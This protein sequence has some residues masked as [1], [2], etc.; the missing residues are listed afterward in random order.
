MPLALVR[1]VTVQK[2]SPFDAQTTRKLEYYFSPLTP[3]YEKISKK[4]VA[5]LLRQQPDSVEKF[6]E[7][8]TPAFLE[9]FSD[10]MTKMIAA[11][12]P[13]GI[14]QVGRLINQVDLPSLINKAGEV[15]SPE[16]RNNFAEV[17][18]LEFNNAS[19]FMGKYG[20][21]IF[22]PDMLTILASNEI[23]VNHAVEV[24]GHLY[25]SLSALGE[26]LLRKDKS[27]EP[28]LT[29]ISRLCLRYAEEKDS[30]R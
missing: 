24:T 9:D 19:Y 20:E 7:E 4:C 23:D 2:V 15:Y 21:S 11:A 26:G 17:M 3:I 5:P 6:V 29:E 8:N 22:G 1:L 13:S 10:I 16:I 25:F 18:N 30:D 27:I 14:E 12:G 28:A